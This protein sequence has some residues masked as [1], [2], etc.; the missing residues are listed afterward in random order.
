MSIEEM[1]NNPADIIHHLVGKL[2]VVNKG[3]PLSL[4]GTKK[5]FKKF[6]PHYLINEI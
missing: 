1:K 6:I 4:I 3:I 5:I 2:I